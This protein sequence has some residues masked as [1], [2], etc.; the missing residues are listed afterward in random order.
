MATSAS[1]PPLSGLFA[2]RALIEEHA[3][4]LESDLAR[5]YAT[6]LRDLWRPG[7][8]SSRLTYRRLRVLID[9]LPAESR[10]KTEI[11][12]GLTQ[13][14]WD[15][16][17]DPQGYGEWSR[18]DH[19]LAAVH[20]RIGMLD[21]TLALVNSKPGTNLPLPR[22]Y[23]RPGVGPVRGAAAEVDRARK[24]A[25]DAAVIAYM[26]AHQGAA[27]P[28]GWDWQAAADEASTTD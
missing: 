25:Q 9:G 17:P 21:H 14:Q 20:D 22:P 19:L 7:G 18:T 16:L 23:P 24:A 8:G 3:E 5:W 13:E 6:D 11:R 28:D 1:E 12:D 2:I 27:P 10:L 26:R 4:A 15:T